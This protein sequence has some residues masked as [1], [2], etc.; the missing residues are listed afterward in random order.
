[1]PKIKKLYKKMYGCDLVDDI[2]GKAGKK[3]GVMI[4]QIVIRGANTKQTVGKGQKVHVGL[5]WNM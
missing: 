1:M 3:A 4:A 5:Y 2:V